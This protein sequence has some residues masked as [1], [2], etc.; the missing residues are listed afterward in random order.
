MLDNAVRRVGCWLVC[1]AGLA[2]AYGQVGSSLPPEVV[3]LARI[4]EHMARHLDRTSNLACLE[5]IH[6]VSL[7]QKGK[8]KHADT[9]RVE[10]A[11]L[12]G[13]EVFSWPGE[14]R[15]EE[16]SLSEIVGLG[17]TSTGGFVSIARTVFLH[18]GI[19]VRFGAKVNSGGRTLFRYDYKVPLLASGYML[20]ISGQGGRV[21]Y[22]GSFWADPETLDVTRLTTR[23]D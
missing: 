14:D 9:V 10:V 15:F 6:R 7:N 13:K 4:K 8:Q 16:R 12:G 2:L 11:Y 23:A 22:S 3:K 5:T 1:L 21:P 20:N 17:A 19:Q 18:K